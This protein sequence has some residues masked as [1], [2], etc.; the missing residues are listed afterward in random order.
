MTKVLSASD[1][2]PF[3]RWVRSSQSSYEVK[4]FTDLI[5]ESA[6]GST[7]FISEF[8]D[9]LPQQ[10]LVLVKVSRTDMSQFCLQLGGLWSLPS[11]DYRVARGIV[12]CLS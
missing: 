7:K 3:S 6:S 9:V 1:F 10:G 2:R 5:S 11:G 4:G 12:P 8:K